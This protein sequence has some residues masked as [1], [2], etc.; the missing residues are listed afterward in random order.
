M[1]FHLV[2]AQDLNCLCFIYDCISTPSMQSVPD[3]T[4]GLSFKKKQV[5]EVKERI[6]KLEFCLDMKI[7]LV[8]KVSVL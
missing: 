8:T 4:F 1:P 2:F 3:W 6:R 7:Q 5:F